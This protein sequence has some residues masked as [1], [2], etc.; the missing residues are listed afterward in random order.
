M[1]VC[2]CVCVTPEGQL[3]AYLSLKTQLELPIEK[4]VA[5]AIGNSLGSC[6]GEP[7]WS[8]P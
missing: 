7:W 2:V 8:L 6:H 4:V 3:Q 5:Q 1:F